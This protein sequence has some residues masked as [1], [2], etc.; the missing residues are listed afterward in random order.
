MATFELETSVG[1][2]NSASPARNIELHEPVSCEIGLKLA[3][4]RTLAKPASERQPVTSGHLSRNES[5]RLDTP[6]LSV[7]IVNY[8][9][10]KN[11]A[12]LVSQLRRCDLMR[13]QAAEV[14]IVDNHSPH[15][16]IVS[17]L[18]RCPG[19]SLR[20]WGRN[21]GFSRAVNEGVR[22]SRGEW[23]LLLNPDMSLPPDFLDQ[24]LTEA[25][26]ILAE[27]QTTGIIG[28][29]LKDEDGSEQLSTGQ[30][31]TFAGTLAGLFR[32]RA[33]R[34]YCSLPGQGKGRV[35]WVTG[36]CMLVRRSCL[37]AL[38]GLDQDFF[39]YYED[40]DLCRRATEAGYTV[41][42]TPATRAIHL[43]PLHRRAVPATLRVVTRHSLLTYGLKHWSRWQFF[44]LAKIIQWEATCRKLLAHARGDRTAVKLFGRLQHITKQMREGHKRSA[45]KNLMRVT[46]TACFY[47][48]SQ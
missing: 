29:G 14:L 26:A 18:R 30:F 11:T 32:S 21:R 25:K 20:R 23:V 42:F 1:W 41:W 37:D 27:D 16:P 40:V 22:L 47:Q 35:D 44:L 5:L 10:W 45:R 15:D 2:E 46:K 9:Q 28:F 43:N 38:G 3:G 39:L 8:Y 36:C 13:S 17:K 19:V 7:V 31:P 48:E 12:M 24:V 6:D 34:K 33:K 4:P